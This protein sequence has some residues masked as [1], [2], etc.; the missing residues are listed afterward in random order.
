[1]SSYSGRHDRPDAQR[2][3]D[4][5]GRCEVV[6][7][8]RNRFVPLE[9]FGLRLTLIGLAALLAAIPFAALIL[10]V[11][12]SW[13][14]LHSLDFGIARRLN[15]YLAE[16]HAQVHPWKL[17]S[18]IGGPTEFRSAAA[19]AAVVLWWRRRRRSA[20]F[21]VVTMVAAA[22]L[23]GV[24]KSLV[25]R[26]RPVLDV[27]V[28]RAPGASFPSGHALTSLVAV[29]VLLVA[30]WPLLSTRWRWVLSTVGVVVVLLVGFSRIILGVHFV[31]DVVGGW[32][33]GGALLLAAIGAFHRPAV[34]ELREDLRHD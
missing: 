14:P 27:P 17:V 5:A 25:H 10:L 2:R 18:T 24:T 13:G 1:V 28:D 21:V 26:A 23:S 3:F 30:F 7:R 9:R 32:L 22:V 31:S 6:T 4:P 15:R 34:P 12:D 20:V 8:T 33:I 16:H 11:R 19:V 29:G